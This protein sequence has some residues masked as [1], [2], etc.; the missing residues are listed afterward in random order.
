MKRA[1]EGFTLIEVMV[2]LFILS[3]S[4][5][6][7]SE[8]QVR[9]MLRVWQSREDIDRIYVIKKYLY[10]M[11]FAP[12]NAKKTSQTFDAPVMHMII[13]PVEIHKKSA[14]APYA[15]QLQF[16]RATATWE[17]G[18]AKRTLELV[19]LAP[20]PPEKAVS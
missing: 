15:R 14:L 20:R 18:S 11:Y 17:R 6:V 8:L 3:S 9:S 1:N 2:A 12:E 16:L 4:L 13:E 10:R 19:A 5:F 7:L